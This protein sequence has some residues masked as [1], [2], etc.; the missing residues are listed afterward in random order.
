MITCPAYDGSNEKLVIKDLS[1]ISITFIHL[2][3][4]AYARMAFIS[5]IAIVF[6]MQACGPAINDKNE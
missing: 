4:T 6:P 1:I 5:M 3:S 2:S